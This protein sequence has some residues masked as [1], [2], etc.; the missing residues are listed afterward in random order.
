LTSD[1]LEE[2]ISR[3]CEIKAR[4]VEKDE[5][6]SALRA[7]LNFGHTVGHALEAIT[8]Y[9][10]YRH[11]E[12]IAAGM[13]TASLIGEA[14]GLTP[15]AATRALISVLETAGFSVHIPDSIESAAVVG[16]LAWDKKSVDGDARFVL[17]DKIGHATPGHRVP[18]DV[19]MA[20]LDRQ[21]RL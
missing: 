1:F 19:V 12:A 4:I 16:L 18:V 13:V 15:E 20:A 7:I 9:R 14:V 10:V 21:R 3:S 8:H 17:L 11:G 6:D 2:A 5:L